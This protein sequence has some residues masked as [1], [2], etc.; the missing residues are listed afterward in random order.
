MR[1]ILLTTTLIAVTTVSTNAWAFGGIV[2]G[3][4]GHKSH[5]SGV[6]SIGVHYNGEGQVDVDIRTCDS[7][8][9]ELVGSECCKKTLVYDDNGVS[10]CCSTEGYAVQDGKCKKQCGEGLVLNEE[11]NECEDACP[12]ERRCG[13]VC[14][15][16]N[17]VCHPELNICC[18]ED[19]EAWGEDFMSVC[20]PVGSPG[21]S[22]VDEICCSTGTFLTETIEGS[23]DFVCCPIG[24]TY[25]NDS[26]NCI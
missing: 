12:A 19:Y 2:D 22:F 24:T 23:H 21:Y 5:H 14:C 1:K 3:I 7:E 11:T 20:C 9:E 15:G 13:D 8:T 16:A 25:D 10:K 18:G 4:T 6:S 26:G 17:N